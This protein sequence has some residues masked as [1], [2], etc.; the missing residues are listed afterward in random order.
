MLLRLTLRC[1]LT[2]LLLR[3]GLTLLL[4]GSRLALLLL[5]GS[6]ALLLLGCSLTL[7]LRSS[8]ALLLLWGGLALLLLWRR[9]TLL[10]GRLT[11][12]LLRCR[13][14][15]LLLWRRLALL[16]LLLNRLTLLLLLLT[17]LT[18]L[19]LLR[20]LIAYLQRRWGPDI[21]IR[22]KRLSDGRTGRTAMIDV[23]KLSPVGAGNVLIPHLC[24]HG[25]SMRLT[26]SRQFRRPGTHLQAAPSAI[27]THTRAAPVVIAHG[28]VV[29]VVHQGDIDVVDRAVVVEVAAAP[30]AA[31]VAEA[32][33]A[34]AVVDAAI[35]ADVRTPIATVKPVMVMPVAPVARRPQGTLVRSLHPR[36]GHP[37]VARLTIGPV[38]GRPQIAIAGSRRLVVVG[39][40]R[41]RLIGGIRRLLSVARIIRWLC[42][43]ASRIGRRSALLGVVI[44]RRL[45]AGICG[46][47]V[48]R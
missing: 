11:L 22:R 9:L 7:L 45:S 39:Q 4:L 34:E 12:L 16:L 44:H 23:R 42:I 28:A 38:A 25:R 2:L 21:A 48:D 10:R 26:A 1:G 43:V 41:R 19:L 13:L 8:L 40:G 3:R 24:S 15:L 31:L 33:V 36:A 27:E 46:G 37:V 5:W 47:L 17:R 30:I 32:D 29:D 6:L 18:L 20:S 14:A 35:V